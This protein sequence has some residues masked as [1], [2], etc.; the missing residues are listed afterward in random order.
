MVDHSEQWAYEESFLWG[1]SFPQ[2]NNLKQSPINIDTDSL[3]EC[4][5]LCNMRH[6]FTSSTCF[7]QYKNKTI[8]IRP[9][10]GSYTEY[11]S[12]LYELK[13]ISIHTPSLH[14]IDGQKFDLEICLI[15]KLTDNTSQNAGLMVCTMFERGPHHGSPEQFISQIINGIPSDP[16]NYDKEINVSEDW[17]PSMLIPKQSG[18]FSYQGSLPYPPCQEGYNVFVYEKVG[19]IGDTNIETFKRYLGNNARPIRPLGTRTIF[20]TPFMKTAL[21]EKTVYSSNNKYLKCRKERHGKAI[22]TSQTVAASSG[23]LGGG[24]DTDFKNRMRGILLSIII[25]LLL[26]NS[27]FFVKFLYRHF[28]IQKMLRMFGGAKNIKADTIRSWKNCQGT[29]ITPE[30]KRLIKQAANNAEAA[31]NASAMSSGLTGMG[32]D[33]RSM[34]G[35][36]QM[37]GPMMQGTTMSRFG[38]PG[39]GMGGYGG[40]SGYGGQPG[41]G[42]GGYGGQPGYGRQPGYGSSSYPSSGSRGYA[43]STYPGQGYRR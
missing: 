27:V 17:S 41:M 40:Q 35:F 24:L 7:V 30:Q 34:Q 31:T 28:Y 13:E 43:S 18:Y 20:Y 23:D 1:N 29:I 36:R 19:S 4:R 33:P 5:T 21:S 22:D 8:T 16:I 37:T 25:L 11:Q 2:C 10:S 3:K 38:Q 15:H 42:T 32:M 14:S 39:M 26:V 9:S 6:K 12:T